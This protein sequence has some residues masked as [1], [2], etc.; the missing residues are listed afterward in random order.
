MDAYAYVLIAA[1]VIAVVYILFDKNRRSKFRAVLDVA[2]KV[3]YA[4][5]QQYRALTGAEKKKIA[6]DTVNQILDYLG[7]R[8]VPEII[9]D[10]AIELAVSLMNRKRKE[11]ELAKQGLERTGLDAQIS[12]NV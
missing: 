2:E 9:I 7:I 6:V 8:D 1:L 11:I 3:V 4:V 5:E 12:I 10:K